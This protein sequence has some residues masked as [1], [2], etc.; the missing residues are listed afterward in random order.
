M[1]YLIFPTEVADSLD[2][3]DTFYFRGKQII[4]NVTELSIFIRPLFHLVLWIWIVPKQ[5]FLWNF[6]LQTN[7]PDR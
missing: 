2:A 3:K 5:C 7:E 4:L 1:F 6:Q